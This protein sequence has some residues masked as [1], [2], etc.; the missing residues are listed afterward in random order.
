MIKYFITGA[1]GVLG[2]EIVRELLTKTPYQLVLLMRAKDDIELQERFL[3]LTNFLEIDLDVNAKRVEIIQGDV[4]L[5]RLGI[6]LKVYNELSASV[7]HII[8]SAASVRMNL[9]LEDARRAAVGA[10][11]NILQFARLCQERGNLHKIE[12]VSTVGVG[13]R[14][15]NHLPERWIN[16]PRLYHN[17]YEQ[18]KAEAEI[19]MEQKTTKYGLPLTVHRPSMII[20]N[21]QNG[22]IIQFQIFYHLVEFVSGR[23][24]FGV[25]PDFS[26]RFIDLIPVDYVA[27]VIVW[28][29]HSDIT[30]GRI[31]HLCSGPEQSVA[32]QELKREVV[33]KFREQ[34]ITVS[35]EITLSVFWFNLFIYLLVPFVSKQSSRKLRVLPM[36]LDYLSEDQVFSNI[37]TVRLLKS[38][39]LTIPQSGDYL[40][41]VLD[42]YFSK[43]YMKVGEC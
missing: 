35:R 24:T 8:H 15:R 5:E 43:I 16:E 28:S 11:E 12:M 10:T 13:G 19:V 14:W 25:L 36:F 38:V 22:R 17:T 1:T 33:K 3:R 42:Y 40:D 30:I 41:T 2:S 7:S 6:D 34:D 21:S 20:G 37:E 32:L 18:A 27:Q 39:G 23:R 9:S 31:L 4:E 29:S 26:D